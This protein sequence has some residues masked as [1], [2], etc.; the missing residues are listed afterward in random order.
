MIISPNP[1]LQFSGLKCPDG[2][3]CS[4]KDG[5]KLPQLV[6]QHGYWRPNATSSVFSDCRQGYTGTDKEILAKKRCCPLGKCNNDT[7]LMMNENG[8]M[9]SHPDDQCLE[10]YSGALCLVCAENFVMQGNECVDCPGGAVVTSALISLLIFA[11]VIFVIVLLIFICAPSKKSE[12]KSN[13]YLGQGKFLD[14]I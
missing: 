11:F 14:V 1:P 4:S 12:D 13:K 9:F 3:D 2:A 6:A 8:T 10:G 5:L 7:L